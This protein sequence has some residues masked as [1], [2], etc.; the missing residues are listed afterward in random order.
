MIVPSALA[1]RMRTPM[2][3]RW[4]AF[5]VSVSSL[6]MS[7]ASHAQR[8]IEV[9]PVPEFV[10]ERR[11]F[12]FDCLD[13][14]PGKATTNER[15]A[16]LSMG[17]EAP[18]LLT[19]AEE[20][21]LSPRD[22]PALTITADPSHSIS[23]GGTGRSDWSIRFC[24]QGEGNSE[25]E[26]RGYLDQVSMTFLGTIVSLKG[27][28]L[29][30]NPQSKGL[31]VLD[32]PAD[33]P[34]VIHGSYASVEIRDMTGPVRVTATHARAKI[35]DTTGQVDAAAFVIDFAGSRGRVNL[36]AEA[37]I[38]LKMTAPRF[39]GTLLA[40]AQRPLR[41]LVPPGF[42]TPFQALVNR[43]QDFVCRTDFCAKV[44]QEKKNGLYVFT[45]IGDG[46]S[47]PELVH[48]RSEQATV[49]IDSTEGKQAR[50]SR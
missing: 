16:R 15:G 38:N 33:A 1:T 13:R 42:T 49:V 2:R 11:P 27:P 48:L 36:S 41:M 22:V 12:G 28:I 18:F 5:L 43:P 19:H 23:I 32:A 9:Q 26:A 6:F 3:L 25:A 35:L 4:P 10:F 40:W 24:A 30:D 46:G 14:R 20:L 21:T 50:D 47:A 7:C 45:Y 17:N 8:E 39:E 31:F 37:G 44:K 29:S 34:I